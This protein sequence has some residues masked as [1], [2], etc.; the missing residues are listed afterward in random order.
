MVLK[1]ASHPSTYNIPCFNFGSATEKS[2]YMP[3]LLKTSKGTAKIINNKTFKDNDH[4]I[5][6]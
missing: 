2:H 4:S 6:M 5:T 3:I 1:L